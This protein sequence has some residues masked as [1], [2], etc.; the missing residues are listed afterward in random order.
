MAADKVTLKFGDDGSE[1]FAALAGIG[2]FA[3]VTCEK[4]FEKK[5]KGILAT[6]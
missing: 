3:D 1:Q 2:A 6:L 4:V 5:G